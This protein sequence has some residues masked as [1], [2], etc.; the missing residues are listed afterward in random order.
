MG[1]GAELC[2]A[3]RQVVLYL[4]GTDPEGPVVQ[5]WGTLA[6]SGSTGA[7]LQLHY[8]ITK[9]TLAAALLIRLGGEPVVFV[10]T[11]IS[12]NLNR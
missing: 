5:S 3:V 10:A 6:N 8:S 12:I 11:L 7:T 9:Y 2:T 1:T 4:T